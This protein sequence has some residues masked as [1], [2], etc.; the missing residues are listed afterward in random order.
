[1]LEKILKRTEK[2]LFSILEVRIGILKTLIFSLLIT[3]ILIE[4]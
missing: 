4:L 3:D 2:H 1:M